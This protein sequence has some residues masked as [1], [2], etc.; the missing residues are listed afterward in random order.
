[1]T[2]CNLVWP[3]FFPAPESSAPSNRA[4]IRRASI[5]LRTFKSSCSFDLS[6]S[7]GF[8][9]GG[10]P[11]CKLRIVSPVGNTVRDF[12]IRVKLPE[13]HRSREIDKG[14]RGAVWPLPYYQKVNALN[15]R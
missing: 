14:P 15:D 10:G 3:S 7:Y 11:H 8:F 13:V 1:M 9:I 6:T 5:S 4:A 12:G 2:R